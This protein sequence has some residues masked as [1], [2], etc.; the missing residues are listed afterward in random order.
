[1]NDSRD[2]VGE[3]EQ[4]VT[5]SNRIAHEFS[6]A[7]N[8]LA[9]ATPRTRLATSLTTLLRSW[10]ATLKPMYVQEQRRSA[11]A[12]SVHQNRRSL[13]L[14]ISGETYSALLNAYRHFLQMCVIHV[15]GT[16]HA[17][18]PL[19]EG[20]QFAR[21]LESAFPVIS[22]NCWSGDEML[23]CRAV[24]ETMA[25]D[26]GL[27]HPRLNP[28]RNLLRIDDVRLQIG[29]ADVFALYQTLNN[30]VEQ[31]IQGVLSQPTLQ[32]PIPLVGCAV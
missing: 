8:A 26:S 24:S 28:W 30:N 20:R 18:P 19:P 11:N 13:V 32:R 5:S 22:S 16:D 14:D 12:K 31:L 6:W 7:C 1:M 15:V 25:H 3:S 23:M 10:Q 27:N 9:A 29:P 17:L 4:S 21:R 2:S